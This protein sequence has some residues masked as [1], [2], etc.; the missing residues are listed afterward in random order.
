MASLVYGAFPL[1]GAGRFS[2]QRCGT[3]TLLAAL[4]CWGTETSESVPASLSYTCFFIEEY[5]AQKFAVL[6]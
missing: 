3:A 4:L 5:V 6:L 2:L 1:E